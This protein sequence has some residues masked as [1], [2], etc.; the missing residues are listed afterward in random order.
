[1]SD[2]YQLATEEYYSLKTASSKIF[3]V[4][5]KRL[6][7]QTAYIAIKG[8][9]KMTVLSSYNKYEEIVPEDFI[10]DY[11][12]SHCRLIINNDDSILKTNNLMRD[13]QTR[14]MNVSAQLQVKGYLGVTLKDLKGEA[15]GTLCVMDKEEKEF[16]E[17]DVEFLKSIADVLSHMIELDQTQYNMVL[18]NVPI[19]PITHGVAVVP[20]QGIIDENRADKLL[21][22]VLHH[23][24]AYD[25]DHFIID[26]SGLVNRGQKFPRV[27]EQLVNALQVMGI[28]TILTGITPEI[29]QREIDSMNLSGFKPKTV[30]NLES[31]LSYIGF[32]LI[33][34]QT[35]P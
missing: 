27:L 33:E 6:N 20:L 29:A 8:K 28:H 24:A 34:K 32:K 26:L 9:R 3:D 13:E 16:D 30:S 15:F 23:G 19:I 22:D 1:M 4:I 5:T 10:I 7:V 18:I 25:I 12:E 17:E 2:E 11:K 31:A 14:E 21:K 35:S